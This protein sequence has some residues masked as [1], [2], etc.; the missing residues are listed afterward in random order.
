MNEKEPYTVV[1]IG[2]VYVLIS[3]DGLEFIRIRKDGI[4]LEDRINW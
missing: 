1:S 3:K 2:T 4:P